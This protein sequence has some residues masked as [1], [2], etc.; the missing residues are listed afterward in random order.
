MILLPLFLCPACTWTPPTPE[1][2]IAVMQNLNAQ[3]QRD[4]ESMMQMQHN[5]QRI[6]N[7]PRT[8]YPTYYARPDPLY[9]GGTV[10]SPRRFGY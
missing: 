2:R 9:P 4:H 5:T 8:D 7:R 3:A 6:L 1:Q 10:I